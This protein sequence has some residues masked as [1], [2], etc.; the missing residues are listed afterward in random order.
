MKHHAFLLGAALA[1]SGCGASPYLK[2]LKTAEKIQ[3]E[4]VEAQKAATDDL[5]KGGWV[6]CN[7]WSVRYGAK[8]QAVLDAR[9]EDAKGIEGSAV[10]LSKAE[11]DASMVKDFFD[12][13]CALAKRTAAKFA[14]APPPVATP[15]AVT[16][17]AAPTPAAPPVPPAVPV[18]PTPPVVVPPAP[19]V[20]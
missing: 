12:D 7:G 5:V 9:A 6:L 19:P 20:Q 15:P 16:P 14:P 2:G 18:V 4:S 10:K 8:A 3:D 11:A 13:W 1:L 17:P